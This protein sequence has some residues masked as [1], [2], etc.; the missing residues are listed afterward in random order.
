MSDSVLCQCLMSRRMFSE[1]ILPI[2]LMVITGPV[3]AQEKLVEKI[4]VFPPSVQLDS[5]RDFQSIVVQATRNDGVTEDVTI[6]AEMA[7]KH[8]EFAGLERVESDAGTSVRLLPKL[9]GDTVLVVSYGGQQ[10]E[11]PVRVRSAATEPPLSFRMDVM[12]VFARAG[13]NMGSCHGAARGKDG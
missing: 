12:P 8:S 9:D 1:Y 6:P 7:F 3:L 4:E 2:L 5:S 10:V 13:C 11:L